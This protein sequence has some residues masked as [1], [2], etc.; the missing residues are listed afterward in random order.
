MFVR[1]NT[2]LFR[3]RSV[4]DWAV[5]VRRVGACLAGLLLLVSLSAAGTPAAVGPGQGAPPAAVPAYRQAKNVAII[6]IHGPIDRRTAESVTRRLNDAAT[7]NADAVVIELNTPGGDVF[8]T[9]DICG[10]IKNSKIPNTIAWVRPD[11]ISAGAIIALACK[12]IVLADRATMGDAGAIAYNP[13]VGI[14]AMPELERQKLTA[15]LLV[16]VVNSARANGYDEKLVQGFVT[17]GVELWL[18]ENAQRPGEYLFIDRSE[19]KLIFG[20]DPAETAPTVIAAPPIPEGAKPEPLGDPDLLKKLTGSMGE[21]SKSPRHR[22]GRNEPEPTAGPAA[23]APQD[24]AADPFVPAVPNMDPQFKGRVTQSMSQASA[25]PLITD[26]DAGKWKLIERVSDGRSFFTLRNADLFRYGLAVPSVGKDGTINS[27]DE[28]K[29]HLGATNL[30]RL[31]PSVWESLAGFFDNP[32]VKGVLIV[33]FLLG[34]FIE[35]THPGTVIAG[36][37]AAVALLLILAPPLLIGLANWWTI[38]AVLLGIGL[39]ALE[40]F[41]LPGFG[42]FG[43]FGLVLLFGGLVGSFIPGAEGLFPDSPE[44]QR[45]LIHGLTTVVLSSAIAMVAA[46]FISKH[47]YSIPVFNKLILQDSPSGMSDD[48]SMFVA[49]GQGGPI[50]VGAEG[51]A[52]TPL[53]PAGRAQFGEQLADVVAEMGLIDAGRRVRVVNASP[54][55]VGV[56]ALPEASPD[57]TQPAPTRPLNDQGSRGGVV[58]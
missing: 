17:L 9:R 50:A 31:E 58:A 36:S 43:V 24:P 16:E 15:P 57:P 5:V 30:V 35:M 48:E 2:S 52:I 23:T 12:E 47:A 13:L 18:V 28:L 4:L 6:T 40:I 32:I 56:V 14:Q 25:R 33:V 27:D 20:S 1:M 34:L 26:A 41:V 10:A 21:Q 46:Y 37:V 49:V 44:G 38:A 8:A 29:A 11:A 42:V 19:Y 22:R 55:R 45:G 7:A 54:F 53:R 51:V 3:S 39:L